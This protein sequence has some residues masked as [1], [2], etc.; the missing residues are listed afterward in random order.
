MITRETDYSMRLVLALVGRQS[1]GQTTVSLAEVAN[2]MDIPY[3]FLRKLVKRLVEGGIL[4]SKRG[5]NG[6]VAVAGDPSRITLFDVVKATGPRG[7]EMSPCVSRPQL[8]KRSSLCQ[9]M[10]EFQ[11][12]QGKVDSHLKSVRIADLVAKK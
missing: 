12:I 11:S 8:C 7:V 6:G 4:E 1:L 2:E 9:L 3:R 10:R 5:K